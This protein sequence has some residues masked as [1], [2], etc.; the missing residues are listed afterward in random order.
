MW[1][2]FSVFTL[3]TFTPSGPTAEGDFENALPFSPL[4]NQLRTQILG[5][6]LA[7]LQAA[8]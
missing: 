7:K 4:A 3:R 8:L 6:S 5:T 2:N 1:K